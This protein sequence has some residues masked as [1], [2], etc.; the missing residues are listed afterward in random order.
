MATNTSVCMH[1]QHEELSDVI[2]LLN[3]YH[4]LNPN[5][6]VLQHLG[7]F[8]YLVDPRVSTFDKLSDVPDYVV[9]AMPLFMTFLFMEMAILHLKGHRLL[10]A[11]Y[12]CSGGIGV[13]HLATNFFLYGAILRFYD[14]LYQFRVMELPGDS[15]YTWIASLL[16]VDF[17]FYWTH[18]AHHETNVLWMFHQV[19]H[20]AEDYNFSVP[21]RLP[22]LLKVT[23]F[24]LYLPLAFLGVPLSSTVVHSS[25]N[26]LFD[27]W[28]HTKLVPYLGPIEWV[29]MTPSS[30]RVHHG[31]NE[32]CIDKNYGSV[33]IIWDRIFGTYEPERSD[34]EIVYGLTTQ[35]MTQNALWHQFYYFGELFK[36]FRAMNTWGDRFKSLFYGPG[37]TPGSLRLG[38]PADMTP[39]PVPREPFNP[40]LPQWQM[41]YIII[42]LFTGAVASQMSDKQVE[43]ENWWS[44]I[45]FLFFI[46][47]SV[48]ILTSM[49]DS[50]RWAP[51][52]EAVRCALFTSYA[53]YWP[54]TGIGI[55][56]SSIVVF[57]TACSLLWISQCVNG[58]KNYRKNKLS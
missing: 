7:G 1:S 18:R 3:P 35:T 4:Y 14:W 41:Y 54:I 13:I 17:A 27:F 46:L 2:H 55:F 50:W 21:L 15:V 43:V 33:L 19:H 42:H 11:D 36:K 56:D 34:E 48:G 51:V 40:I 52:A 39:V 8:L 37:W 16:L 6:T 26:L 53:Q 29:L 24:F 44:V 25:L 10:M 57:Y 28:L 47:T 45:R 38:D 9:D 12:I 58:F 31:A 5:Y 23:Y 22:F 30:H 49:Y 20:S 32:W